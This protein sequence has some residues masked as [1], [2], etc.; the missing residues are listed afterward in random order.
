[1]EQFVYVVTALRAMIMR[2]STN[3]SNTMML[4]INIPGLHGHLMR[5]SVNEQLDYNLQM[6][7]AAKN[8]VRKSMRVRQAQQPVGP[9][10]SPPPP[11]EVVDL[12]L[13]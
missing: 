2:D 10:P 8:L 7:D 6:A 9:A 12:T 11:S 13:D 4:A 5:S 3:L 1:M